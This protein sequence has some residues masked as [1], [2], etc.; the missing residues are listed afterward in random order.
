MQKSEGVD[1]EGG[2]AVGES[3][4]AFGI[5]ELAAVEEAITVGEFGVVLDGALL[6][7]VVCRREHSGGL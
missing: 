3:E 4:G 5:G 2:V 6:R 1:A 7:P